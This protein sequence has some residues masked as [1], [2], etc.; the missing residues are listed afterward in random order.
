M[1]QE[2]VLVGGW[3]FRGQAEGGE[4]LRIQFSELELSRTR[5]G[6]VVGRHPALCDFVIDEAAVSRRHFRVTLQNA[7]A[8]IEDLNS[9][10]GTLV[11]DQDLAPFESAPLRDG[12]K[13]TLGDLELSV[14]RIR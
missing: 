11:D 13:V 9:L 4:P 6:L 14:Q 5:N 2:T 7:A 12:Q 10:N 8:V 3:L 1:A